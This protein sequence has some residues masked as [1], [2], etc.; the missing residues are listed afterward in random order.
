MEL[1]PLWL[2]NLLP[3]ANDNLP[4]KNRNWLSATLSA[5]VSALRKIDHV[6]WSI[7][8]IAF[9]IC[10]RRSGSRNSLCPANRIA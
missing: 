8:R 2:I 10:H 4:R 5:R 7:I 1:I 3:Y 9:V 6:T